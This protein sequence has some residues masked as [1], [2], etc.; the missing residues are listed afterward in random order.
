VT[1]TARYLK[2]KVAGMCVDCALP[3]G[4]G[5]RCE[6]C[7]ERNNRNR[8]AKVKRPMDDARR[9]AISR[10]LVARSLAPFRALMAARVK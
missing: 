6:W 9:A 10:A 1:R 8:R 5:V 3:A 4:Y 2:Y 7:R